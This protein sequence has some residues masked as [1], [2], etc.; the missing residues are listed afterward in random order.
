MYLLGNVREI[1]KFPEF[2]ERELKNESKNSGKSLISKVEKSRY[3]FTAP[4]KFKSQGK[5]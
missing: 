4:K 5:K 1:T 2:F 3:V